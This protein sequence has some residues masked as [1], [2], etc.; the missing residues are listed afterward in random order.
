MNASGLLADPDRCYRAVRS[1]DGRF[2]GVFYTGVTTTGIYCR[3]SCPA[4]TPRRHN[5]SFFATAAAALDAG[6]RACRR[7]RP[8]S[9]PGSPEWDVRADVC[10]R[11]M[12]LIA[13]GCV[14]REGVAGLA[15]R[16]GY[17]PRQLHRLLLGELGAGPLALARSRR[18]HTARIL[19]ET[20]RLPMADVA[21][22]AGF[23]SIRQFN[24]TVRAVYAA[25]PS[26]L[27]A[28]ALGSQRRDASTTAVRIR[29]AVRAPFDG[30][31]LLAFFAARTVHGVENVHDG[32]YTRAISLPYGQGVVTLRPA[33]GFVACELH[34]RDLRDLT[35]A[36]ERC[37]RL[38]DLDAD[39]RAVAEVLG[40]DTVL[41]PLVTARPGLRIPGYADGFEAVVRAIIGQQVSVAGARTL[42]GRLVQRFGLPLAEPSGGVTHLFPTPAAL[43][44]A[45]P[46]SLGM[47]QARGR[48]LVA[49]SRAV[50]SQAIALDRSGDRAEVAERLLA[51]PGV[52]PWTAGYVALRA[53]GDPDVFL[54][55]D[56]GVRQAMARLGLPDEPKAALTY[57]ERWRPWRSYAQ[58][59]LW[60]GT[61]NG[62]D[63]R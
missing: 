23:A 22:A 7:C 10:G 8:D 12:R 9:T 14:D 30:A 4:V 36:V 16:L 57:A 21:F 2:D 47:P 58:M 55:S 60:T 17:S 1:R 43:A 51:L 20:T 27:R 54:A 40:A 42:A 50:E 15:A 53:L 41:A 28:G 56:L 29:L 26:E 49:V 35:A 33:E 5:V 38:F 63:K 13:D 31:A 25:R 24:D 3:P 61:A 37:R 11:A 59:H 46:T 18:A 52:G 34:L 39:P 19:I 45:D 48:A 62:E 6:F 44:E 32:A